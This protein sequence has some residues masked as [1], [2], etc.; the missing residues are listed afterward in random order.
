MRW[1]DFYQMCIA[2]LILIFSISLFCALKIEFNFIIT[3]LLTIFT[4]GISIFFYNESTKISI[5]IKELMTK[6]QGDVVASIKQQTNI[7]EKLNTMTT[8]I[9]DE[10]LRGLYKKDG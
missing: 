9:N 7:T 4:I 1:R 10:E 3:L 5:A 2:F 8:F 6:M